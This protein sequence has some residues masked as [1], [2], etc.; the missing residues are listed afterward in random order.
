MLTWQPSNYTS[1]FGSLWQM[2]QIRSALAIASLL[3][4]TLVSLVNS[5]CAYLMVISLGSYVYLVG[6]S[7]M[8]FR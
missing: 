3:N 8:F 1:S 6:L 5:L 7:T 2:K 4:R